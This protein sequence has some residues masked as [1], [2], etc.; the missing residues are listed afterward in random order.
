MKRSKQ[1]TLVVDELETRSLLSGFHSGFG[2]GGH[3]VP[4]TPSPAVQADLAKI[5]QD[6]QQLQTDLTS[7]APTLQADWQAIQTAITNSTTVQAAKQTLTADQAA[8]R[9]TLQADWQAIGS[10]TDAT[11]RS[12][13]FT[14]LKSDLSSGI[15]V[16]QT[17]LKAIQTAITNDPTVQA[18]KQKLQ[19]DAQPIINDQ[20]TLQADYTQLRKDQQA[21]SSGASG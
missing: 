10:A 15:T 4:T 21:Q 7:L 3:G 9:S 12:A 14:K 8:F 18:A 1:R 17:D 11:T 5:Q 20:A 13:A 19:T 6:Q 2:L 16:I